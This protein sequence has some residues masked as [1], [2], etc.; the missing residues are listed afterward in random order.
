VNYRFLLPIFLLMAGITTRA[1]C[2]KPIITSPRAKP[3]STGQQITI[4]WETSVAADSQVVYGW[5]NAGNVT[6]VTDASGV[7]SHS[8]TVTGLFPATSYGWGII[9]HAISGGVQ[10]PYQYWAFYAGGDQDVEVVTN[11]A[12]PGSADYYLALNASPQHVTQGFG[13]YLRLWNGIVAGTIGTNILQVLVTGLPNNVSLTW[14]DPQVL[15]SGSQSVSTTTITNDTLTIRDF[16][17][18]GAELYILTNQGGTTTPGTYTLTFTGS[19]AGIPM[20]T[21]TW[22]LVVDPVESPFGITFPFG[23]PSSYPEIPALSTFLS[24]ASTYGAY[25]CAQ[26]LVS[27]KSTTPRVNNIGSPTTSTTSI[28]AGTNT[29]TVGSTTGYSSNLTYPLWLGFPAVGEESI[30]PGNW[31]VIDGTHLR[32]TNTLSHTQPYAVRVDNLTPVGASFQKGSWYY[33]GARVYYNIGDLLGDQGAYQVCVQNVNQ[34]FRDGYVIPNAGGIQIFTG[35][36]TGLMIDYQRHGI[37]ADLTAIDDL[38]T[39]SQPYVPGGN[40]VPVQ[41]L[42]RETAYA[43]KF[44]RDA[45]TLGQN[46]PRFGH[47]SIFWRAYYL[48][49]VIGHLDEICLTGDYEYEENFMVGLE[50]DAIINYYEAGNHD[51]RIPS[52][53]KCVAD[54]LWNTQWN[55]VSTDTNSFAYDSYRAAVNLNPANAPASYF[56]NLNNLIDPMYAW[57][58]KMTGLS[59]YQVEGDTIFEHG[60][61]LDGPDGGPANVMGDQNGP[62]NGNSGK[63]FSQQY[64]WG[65]EYV[66]WRSTPAIDTASVGQPAAPTNLS[67]TVQ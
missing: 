15:G 56:Q 44:A 61:L 48:D 65:P 26:D 36:T 42:Q 37:A 39:S 2:T 21:V 10:C 45:I 64:M 9:S 40:A 38:D 67:G 27:A 57:L 4:S 19:G 49:H 51:V 66:T 18:A 6:R 47:G 58:F 24:S 7:T 50:A 54:F 52:A 62:P 20:H 29:I 23:T 12:P 11:A 63:E 43:F 30:G 60:T 35:F 55:V 5:I 31:S 8:V 32:I 16:G 34:V 28:T 25:N 59:R 41:Y 3:D 33:D 53:I 17:L 22:K 13:V 14:T 1:A 46:N